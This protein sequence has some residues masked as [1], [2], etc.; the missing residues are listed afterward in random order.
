MFW[1]EKIWMINQKLKELN[2]IE[3]DD[4]IL[5]IGPKQLIKLKV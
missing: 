1:L 4:M 5:D 2:D 3:N